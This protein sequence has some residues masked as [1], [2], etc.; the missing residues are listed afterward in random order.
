MRKLDERQERFV[1]LYVESGNATK[2]CI[3]AGYSENSASQKG[4]DLKNRYADVIEQRLKDA[5]RDKVPEAMLTISFLAKNANSET[6]RLAA[7][8]D[9]AD[10][11]GMKPT[12]K[13]EQQVTNIEKSTDELRHELARLLGDELIEI[14][15]IPTTL[16]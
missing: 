6:V 5:V 7:A 11:G 16:N 13:I 1:R 3:E 9:I 15:E 14:E 8:K 2:A 10:R 4:W 12:D